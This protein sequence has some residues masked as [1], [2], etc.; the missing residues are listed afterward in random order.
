M[1]RQPWQAVIDVGTN[2]ALLLLARPTGDG[3]LEVADDRATITRLGEGVA[4][5]G[6][7]SSAAIERTVAA[8]RSYR[9]AADACGATIRAVTTEGVRLAR[10]PEA[11]LGPA[12]AAL[13]VPVEVIS[14]DEEARLSYLSVAYETPEGGPL[15][16]VDIG[17]ASTEVVVGEGTQ[18]LAAVS[19]R[20]GS[21]RLTERFITGDPPTPEAIAAIEAAAREALASQPLPPHPTLHGLAGTVTTAAAILLDLQVYDRDRVDRS[22]HSRAAIL[23]LRDRLAAQTIEERIS[24]V[25]ERKRADVIVAGVTILLAVMDQCGADTLVVRDRG[26]RYA[27]V[28]RG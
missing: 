24:P 27:L 20:I 26:L 13:G 22:V 12:S 2:T 3:G 6:E 23:E 1:Q 28:E 25:L 17:G 16:V 10:N 18:V 8:L 19:H 11:F 5:T 15:R 9:E 14:G 4:K 21:V 7:L